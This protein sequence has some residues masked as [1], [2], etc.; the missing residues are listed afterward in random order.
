MYSATSMAEPRRRCTKWQGRKS[1]RQMSLRAAP[2]TPPPSTSALAP[3]SVTTVHA[4]RPCR[5]PHGAS[6]PPHH[7]WPAAVRC[8]VT[9]LSEGPCR[10]SVDVAEMQGRRGRARARGDA[11]ENVHGC[12]ALFTLCSVCTR[13]DWANDGGD[14]QAERMGNLRPPPLAAVCWRCLSL[15]ALI[16]RLTAINVNASRSPRKATRPTPTSRP[17][18]GRRHCPP[19]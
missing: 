2:L 6:Q 17:R 14:Q 11:S 9:R 5:W 3:C 1:A 19:R 15:V 10:R 16:G 7:E 12:P 4:A 18:C 8:Q 13:H